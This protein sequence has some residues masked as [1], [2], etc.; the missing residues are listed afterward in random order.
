MG[1]RPRFHL[2]C[3]PLQPSPAG[4]SDHV[5]EEEG[6]PTAPVTRALLPHL[7]SLLLFTLLSSSS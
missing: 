1:G 6:G 3:L 2:S 7:Q 4:V 5:L